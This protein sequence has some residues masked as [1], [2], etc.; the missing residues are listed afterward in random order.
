VRV[1]ELWV[2]ANVADDEGV[3]PGDV[4]VLVP[5]A[6]V[7]ETVGTDSPLPDSALLID[8][9]KFPFSVYRRDKLCLDRRKG[10]VK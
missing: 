9:A 3:L 1:D 5:D 8:A 2:L 7:D 10:R 4:D 6:W